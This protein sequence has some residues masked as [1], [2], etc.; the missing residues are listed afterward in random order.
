V[1]VGSSDPWMRSWFTPDVKYCNEPFWSVPAWHPEFW[2]TYSSLGGRG[3]HCKAP[4][5]CVLESNAACE[6][7]GSYPL[8]EDVNCYR[9]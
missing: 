8:A 1:V 3:K 2:S 6:S 5:A 4:R 9:Q 7:R